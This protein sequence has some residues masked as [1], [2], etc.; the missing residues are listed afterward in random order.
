MINGVEIL[1]TE[2]LGTRGMTLKVVVDKETILIDPGV[3][4]GFTRRKLHPHPIQAA[5]GERVKRRI[6]ESLGEARYVVI[7]HLHGDHT[8]LYNANPFQLNL[9]S[10]L[11]KVGGEAKIIVKKR[12]LMLNKELERLKHIARVVGNKLVEVNEGFI[13]DSIEI[14]KPYPHGLTSKTLVVATVVYTS[15]ATIIHAPGE[16]LLHNKVVEDIASRKPDLVFIDGP[17]IYRIPRPLWNPM[18]LKAQENLKVIAE[19][20]KTIIIDHHTLRCDE[21]L[22]W[23]RSLARNVEGEYDCRVET[24]AEYMSKPNLLLEAWRS[25]CYKKLPIENNW[26]RSK[27]GRIKALED[28]GDILRLIE[29]EAVRKKPC[30][31]DDFSFLLEKIIERGVVWRGGEA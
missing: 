1:N 31:E 29:E 4:L 6:I 10:A 23:V 24:A 30:S 9:T 11:E 16:P 28:A 8:P 19:Y 20:A 26:F 15:R 27:L 22:E 12:S 7:S 3:A 13:S 5:A 25:V 17:P 14:T 21:G 18:L 2:S